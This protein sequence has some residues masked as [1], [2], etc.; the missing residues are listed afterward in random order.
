MKTE[1]LRELVMRALRRSGVAVVSKAIGQKPETLMAF[2]I[3]ARREHAGT[4]SLIEAQRRTLE[5]LAKP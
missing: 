4:R 2:A 1:D 5:V 3:G